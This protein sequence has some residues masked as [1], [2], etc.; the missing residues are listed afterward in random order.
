MWRSPFLRTKQPLVEGA[1]TRGADAVVLDFK[2][3]IPQDRKY[4]ARAALSGAVSDLEASG[5]D[6]AVRK[7]APFGRRKRHRHGTDAGVDLI[8]APCH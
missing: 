6:T 8:V 1:A 3:A 4:E 7:P 2:A 5:A